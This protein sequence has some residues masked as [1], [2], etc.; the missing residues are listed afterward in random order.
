MT[1]TTPPKP[2]AEA[3]RRKTPAIIKSAFNQ[4]QRSDQTNKAF[5][6]RLVVQAGVSFCRHG[7]PPAYFKLLGYGLLGYVRR[8][9]DDQTVAVCPSLAANI[10]LTGLT[11]RRW[12]G[13]LS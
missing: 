2:A 4:R 11:A 5:E 6:W 3:G 7:T 9:R 13:R 10:P 8:W 12:R 1:P